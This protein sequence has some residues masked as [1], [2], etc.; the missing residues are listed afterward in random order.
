MHF[1]DRRGGGIYS[2]HLFVHRLGSPFCYNKCIE[3]GTTWEKGLSKGG[4]YS[5]HFFDYR[6]GSPFLLQRIVLK[7]D[8]LEKGFIKGFIKRGH[9]FNTFICSSIRFSLFVTKNCIEKGQPGKR[10]C[11]KGAYILYILFDHR[12]GSL[13]LLQRIVLKRDNL[14]KGFIKGFIKR[15][16]RASV[17][18]GRSPL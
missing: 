8:N 1:G 9:I 7:R 18:G 12:L 13:F 16:E 14:E 4:I 11:Q 15:G 2:I 3:K 10:V 17:P 5:I 6:L